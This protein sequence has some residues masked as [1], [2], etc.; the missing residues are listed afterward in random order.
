LGYK[1][2]G[3]L[4]EK[5]SK[6]ISLNTLKTQSLLNLEFALMIFCSDK[7]AFRSNFCYTL[8]FALTEV[9][10]MSHALN[11]T[12]IYI[13]FCCIVLFAFTCCGLPLYCLLKAR[14]YI[15]TSKKAKGYESLNLI[16]ITGI[17]LSNKAKRRS[18]TYIFRLL[19]LSQSAP[20]LLLNIVV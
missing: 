8:L 3:S 9:V 20:V 15:S 19:N 16:Q 2:Q 17:I 10:I 12:I 11:L 14:L 1:G 4:T 7:P 13:S 6:P 18:S 5:G